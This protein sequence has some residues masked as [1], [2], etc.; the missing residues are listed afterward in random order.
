[1]T[2]WQ[3]QT[4]HASCLEL[5]QSIWPYYD[6]IIAVYPKAKQSKAKQ[7]PVVFVA[8]LPL[9][10]LAYVSGVQQ[11]ELVRAK[12]LHIAT[13]GLLLNPLL[14]LA[15]LLSPL[16]L[17]LL[18][19]QAVLAQ[20]LCRISTTTISSL[21]C[22]GML[23]SYHWREP[24]GFASDQYVLIVQE[25]KCGFRS[26]EGWVAVLAYPAQH[27]RAGHRICCAYHL[28]QE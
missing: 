15:L 2:G 11:P 4:S 8:A 25:C 24:V 10:L 14:L 19:A 23:H 13:L 3:L 9:H 26:A 16:L 27:S 17:L 1:M 12:H 18:L 7:N 5:Q 6:S 21:R 28:P 20:Q 22:L